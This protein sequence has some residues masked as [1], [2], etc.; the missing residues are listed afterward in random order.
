MKSQ[1]N[2]NTNLLVGCVVVLVII[3][4]VLTALLSRQENGEVEQEEKQASSISERESELELEPFDFPQAAITSE[5]TVVLFDKAKEQQ[6]IVN[7]NQ[8]NWKDISCSPQGDLVAVLGETD[9]ENQVY[10]LH[11]F[12]QQTRKWQRST[13]YSDIGAGISGYDWYA[14]NIIRYTQGEQDNNWVHEYDYVQQEVTK[15]YRIEGEIIFQKQLA[16]WT[17]TYTKEPQTLIAWGSDL[18]EKKEFPI[19]QIIKLTQKP[20][21]VKSES[22]QVDLAQDK[23][24][25]VSEIGKTNAA[26]TTSSSVSNQNDS[27]QKTQ[28]RRSLVQVSFIYEREGEKTYELIWL[29]TVGKYSIQAVNTNEE[30]GQLENY[31]ETVK[32]G[33][34]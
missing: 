33:T 25:D 17:I 24:M 16:K 34:T 31:V 2:A 11:I 14:Q 12:N 19:N 29:P 26:Q 10:D 21:Q 22:R 32:C 18:E 20:D 3:A 9:P 5:D 15:L 28:D 6:A 30:L 8:N 7:L 4:L 23:W 13:Y 27:S 1:L